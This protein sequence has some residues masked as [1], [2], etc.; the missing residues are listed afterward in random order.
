MTQILSIRAAGDGSCDALTPLHPRLCTRLTFKLDSIVSSDGECAM[1]TGA[2]KQGT[3]KW[4]R[5]GS[6]SPRA[7]CHLHHQQYAFPVQ[8]LSNSQRAY[9]SRKPRALFTSKLQLGVPFTAPWNDSYRFNL[10]VGPVRQFL[11]ANARPRWCRTWHRLKVCSIHR[12]ELGVVG[13]LRHITHFR[14]Q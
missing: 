1:P 13:D 8:F 5:R 6:R 2:R 11:D 10:Y 3:H 12:S 4:S 9:L 7:S 14:A